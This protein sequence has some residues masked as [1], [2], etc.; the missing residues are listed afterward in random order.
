MSQREL[1]ALL[2]DQHKDSSTHK[3]TRSSTRSIRN[4]SEETD[5]IA[6]L[7]AKLEEA[8][9]TI[10]EQ[11]VDVERAKESDVK[12]QQRLDDAQAELETVTLRAEVEKLCALEKVRRRV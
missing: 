7:E 2:A 3:R 4:M 12:L 5:K 11:K 8:L 10:K 6:E 1:R 9:S